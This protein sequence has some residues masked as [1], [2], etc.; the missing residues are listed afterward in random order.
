MVVFMS[1]KTKVKQQWTLASAGLVDAFT[2]FTLSRMAMQA[3]P[4][5]MAFYKYTAGVFLR[6]IESQSITSPDQISAP[7]VRKYL[8]QLQGKDTTIHDHARAIK[9]LLRFWHAKGYM[10]AVKFDMPKLSKKRLPVLSIVELKTIIQACTNPRDKALILVLVDSGVRRAEVTALDW[11][12]IDFTN[13]LIR[14]ERGKDRKARSVVIGATA[15]RALLAYRRT[16]ADHTGPV[17]PGRFGKQFTGSGLLK[18]FRGLSQL[19]RIHVTPHV[20]RSTFTILTLGAGIDSLHLQALGDWS[21]LT[22]VNY[23]AQLEDV[24]VGVHTNIPQSII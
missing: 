4:A 17:F 14:V 7:H 19:T 3:N 16:L 10:P 5:T 1:P 24:V 21:D 8:A 13:G 20:L 12:N 18:I 23:Y 15:R 22:I 2:D 11:E 6:W 9:P